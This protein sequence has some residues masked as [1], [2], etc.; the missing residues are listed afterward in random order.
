MKMGER[1]CKHFLY[2]F[3]LELLLFLCDYGDDEIGDFLF[4]VWCASSNTQKTIVM[5]RHAI[6]NKLKTKI[7]LII[8][9]R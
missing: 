2:Y 3:R 8:T 6:A 4:Q 7:D 9:S 5:E 1:V